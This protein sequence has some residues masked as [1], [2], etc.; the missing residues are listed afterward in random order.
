MFY[1]ITLNLYSYTI[2]EVC[3]KILYVSYAFF[4]VSYTND[5]HKKHN[6]HKQ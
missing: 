4:R 5:S 3:F 1:T 2:L 6:Y